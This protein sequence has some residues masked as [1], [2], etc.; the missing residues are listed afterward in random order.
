MQDRAVWDKTMKD[1][2][3][4]IPLPRNRER[5]NRS[6]SEKIKEKQSSI[7]CCL[8]KDSV[9]I[10]TLAVRQWRRI[11]AKLKVTFIVYIFAL[12]GLVNSPASGQLKRYAIQYKKIG[13]RTLQI[14]WPL[15]WLNEGLTLLKSSLA[16]VCL[17]YYLKFQWQIFSSL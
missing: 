6:R 14:I 7:R 13:W 1:N 3:N 2:E 16:G 15:S 8:L 12:R 11:S 5:T 17:M 10:L 4:I 9:N